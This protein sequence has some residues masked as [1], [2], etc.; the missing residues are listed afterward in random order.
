[1]Q[2]TA[3]K[4]RS[5]SFERI[6]YGAALVVALNHKLVWWIASYQFTGCVGGFG[7]FAINRWHVTK[8]AAQQQCFL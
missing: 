7:V 3:K 2:S 8:Q 6:D 1:M 5:T 4:R